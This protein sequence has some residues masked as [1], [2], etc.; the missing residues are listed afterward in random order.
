MVVAVKMRAWVCL[1]SLDA[2]LLCERVASAFEVRNL[3][4][5][6]EVLIIFVGLKRQKSRGARCQKS[7]FSLADRNFAFRGTASAF[8]NLPCHLLGREELPVS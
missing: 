5:E 2:F 3:L 7:W 1:L 4:A 8:L 6:E